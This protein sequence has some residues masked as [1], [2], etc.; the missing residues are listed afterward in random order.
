MEP[1]GAIGIVPNLGRGTPEEKLEKVGMLSLVRR[2]RGDVI[3]ELIL[4]M[5]GVGLRQRMFWA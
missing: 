3:A 5:G 4:S 1:A 2:V